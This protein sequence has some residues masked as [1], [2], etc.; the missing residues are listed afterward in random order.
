[1]YVA[2]YVDDI[3]TTALSVKE[4]LQFEEAL[5]GR[6]YKLN[7]GPLEKYIGME[8]VRDRVKRTI[9]LRQSQFLHEVVTKEGVR[10]ATPRI[11]P[12]PPS[13]NLSEAERGGHGTLHESVGRYRYAVDHT[14]PEALYITSQL[15]SAAL[16]PG[17]LTYGQ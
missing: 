17:A 3:L 2:T 15:S 9:T 4:L 16:N 11:L 8:V 6:V 10:D 7:G 1:M 12:C 13:W 14:R 5:R